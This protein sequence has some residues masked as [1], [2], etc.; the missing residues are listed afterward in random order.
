MGQVLLPGRQRVIDPEPAARLVQ[1]SLHG[2]LTAQKGLAAAALELQPT[3]ARVPE[4]GTEQAHGRLAVPVTEELAGVD[5]ALE[6]GHPFHRDVSA[7]EGPAA[8]ALDLQ[9][10]V[11][12]VVKGGAEEP[13]G[14]PAVPVT[15]ELPGVDLAPEPR[16]PVRRVEGIRDAGRSEAAVHPGGSVDGERGRC[17]ATDVDRSPGSPVEV[18]VVRTVT[19]VHL[20]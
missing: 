17:A 6:P 2:D 3:V 9:P 12:Q 18:E 7:H 16:L 13:H 4:D 10:V 20:P 11:A 14:R 8:A 19:A 15:E 5:L 1:G